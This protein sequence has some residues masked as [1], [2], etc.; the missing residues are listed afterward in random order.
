M[1]YQKSFSQNFPIIS[2]GL[3]KP[4]ILRMPKR[5]NAN[6]I[7]LQICA[8][9]QHFFSPEVIQTD[10]K[11]IQMTRNQFRILQNWFHSGTVDSCPPPVPSHPA[12]DN[13]VAA[14][15]MPPHRS[16]PRSPPCC[17]FFGAN[18]LWGSKQGSH[19]QNKNFSHLRVLAPL[20]GGRTKKSQ[21]GG[22]RSAFPRL[23]L[24]LFPIFFKALSP[25][26]F[27]YFGAFFPT[28]IVFRDFCVFWT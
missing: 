19:S 17:F 27:A 13:F 12:F 5:K 18:T 3:S 9:K 14:D 2:R 25:L 20:F 8:F 16:C 23:F 4:G 6:L 21:E 11:L 22:N 1:N 24:R 10:F 28:A 26:I 7:T 15:R